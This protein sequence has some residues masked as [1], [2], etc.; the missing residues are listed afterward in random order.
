MKT[1]T[2]GPVEVVTGDGVLSRTS[3]AAYL[4]VHP[5][6]VVR[7]LI[8]HDAALRARLAAAEARISELEGALRPFAEVDTD[9]WRAD[10]Q[11]SHPSGLAVQT[12]DGRN[13]VDIQD[14]DRARTALE[15]GSDD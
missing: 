1:E 13:W 10:N 6:S 2:L 12:H 8:A 15:G 4:D 9:D 11:C 3:F 14:F 5:A 7:R